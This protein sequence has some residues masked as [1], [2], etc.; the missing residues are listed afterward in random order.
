VCIKCI[1]S[2]QTPWQHVPYTA[3]RAL[4]GQCRR[5]RRL[6]DLQNRN[7]RPRLRSPPNCYTYVYMHSCV[8][9]TPPPE[10]HIKTN[11]V[12]SSHTK[13][14]TNET[15]MK[16]SEHENSQTS[17]CD[18]P[19]N[20]VQTTNSDQIRKRRSSCLNAHSSSSSVTYSPRRYR[21]ISAWT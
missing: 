19:P 5:S 7:T 3:C 8:L 12:S 20:L 4:L 16:T 2:K 17:R 13:A 14:A 21:A 1:W 9:A 18:C 11:T 6:V 10:M 15:D